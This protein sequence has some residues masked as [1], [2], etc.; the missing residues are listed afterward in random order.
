MDN[1]GG[2]L[3]L[4]GSDDMEEEEDEEE[5]EKEEKKDEEEEEEEED[6]EEEEEEDE[7]DKGWENTGAG[8]AVAVAAAGK[9]IRRLTAALSPR[10]R[11][12]ASSGEV[13]LKRLVTGKRKF[14]ELVQMKP[15][16]QA[17][18]IL[19]LDEQVQ[20]QKRRITKV[21]AR[22]FEKGSGDAAALVIGRW[23]EKESAEAADKE[24]GKRA[25]VLRAESSRDGKRQKGPAVPS[26]TDILKSKGGAVATRVSQ[27]VAARSILQGTTMED[28][29]ARPPPTPVAVGK[30]KG[31]VEVAALATT[32]TNTAVMP[33]A[34]NTNTNAA[35]RG[36]VG[37][38]VPVAIANA[39]GQPGP[40]AT[41][42]ALPPA[43]DVTVKAK[44]QGR[45]GCKPPAPAMKP[46]D[47]D[48][49]DEDDNVELVLQRFIGPSNIGGNSGKRKGCGSRNPPRGGGGMV[50]EPWLGGRRRWLGHHSLAEV[51]YLTAI[52]KMCYEKRVDAGL[53]LTP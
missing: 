40:S 28:A 8:A 5:G 2:D 29:A 53:K 30:G 26:V 38:L 51:H 7:E 24:T 13:A 50:G 25:V 33:A 43:A 15:G 45:R 47:D 22:V 23:R 6:E 17:E 46:N 52:A 19:R 1:Q 18:E 31:K 20:T 12:A 11:S 39:S 42:P 49:S 48:N 44:N 9:C 4:E 35:H 32:T 3:V 36:H 21:E 16:M 37:M 27:Y 14:E 34:G 41:A 10:A